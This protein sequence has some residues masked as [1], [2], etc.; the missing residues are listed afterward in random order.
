VLVNEIGYGDA[1]EKRAVKC[2]KSAAVWQ[3]MGKGGGGKGVGARSQ[4]STQSNTS[5]VRPL[6]GVE[7]MVNGGASQGGG[8][9]VT[10][11]QTKELARRWMK[12]RSGSITRRNHI[13]VGDLLTLLL[14]QPHIMYLMV[15]VIEKYQIKSVEL[16]R[17]ALRSFCGIIRFLHVSDAG[18][19]LPKV[20]SSVSNGMGD[21]SG[22]LELRCE[23]A[24]EASVRAKRAQSGRFGCDNVARRRSSARVLL[25]R[26]KRAFLVAEKTR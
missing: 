11:A 9:K 14:V 24:S 20:L 8:V 1:Y 22:D 5:S 4:Q 12:V 13:Y 23:R 17:H 19:Y 3:S 18:L 7:A 10:D 2:I 16:K 15:Q 26:A 21:S 25:E 6:E